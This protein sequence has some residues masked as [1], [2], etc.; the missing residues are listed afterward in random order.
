MVWGLRVT[1]S[2]TEMVSLRSLRSVATS[3]TIE[4]SSCGGKEEVGILDLGA[5]NGLELGAIEL[6]RR[7][8]RSCAVALKRVGEDR[9]CGR[10][11]L[12][13]CGVAR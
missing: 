13:V 4:R 5:V 1:V 7:A 8:R 9:I 2:A 6:V 12:L 11:G 10:C 3:F